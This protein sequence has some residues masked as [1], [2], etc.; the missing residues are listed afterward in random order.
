MLYKKIYIFLGLDAVLRNILSGTIAKE[1]HGFEVCQYGAV[2]VYG[3]DSVAL[4]A[5]VMALQTH[6]TNPLV[7][8][9]LSTGR[10][11]S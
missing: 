3:C 5:P 6:P 10:I 2:L 11:T 7:F 1:D 8:C 4:E 9:G